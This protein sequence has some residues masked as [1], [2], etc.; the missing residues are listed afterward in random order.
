MHDQALAFIATDSYMLMIDG[1]VS[2]EI[3]AAQFEGY[4]RATIAQEMA[5]QLIIIDHEEKNL[6]YSTR[7]KIIKSIWSHHE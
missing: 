7:R 5:A 3:L 4:W 1:K 2:Y 6:P